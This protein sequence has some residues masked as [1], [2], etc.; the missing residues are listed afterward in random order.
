MAAVMFDTHAVIRRLQESGFSEQQAE[1]VTGVLQEAQK[2]ALENLA[3]KLDIQ[4]LQRDLKEREAATQRD[5]Q[6]LRRDLK[7]FEAATKRDFKEL[8]AAT[9]RDL[10][11]LEATTTRDIQ[12]L[13][14]DLKEM[15]T[16]LRKDM[17]V[18]LAELKADLL[19][20]TVGM[21]LAQ[22]AVIAALVKLL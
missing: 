21:L 18:K 16:T 20:W 7:E 19:K 14:R 11:E 10:K 4:D 9:K 8:E 2:T 5:L 12:D 1:A 22:I 17:E 15:E 6:D 13:Q 3:T